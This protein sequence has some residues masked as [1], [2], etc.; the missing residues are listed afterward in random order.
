MRTAEQI[1]A[2]RFEKVVKAGMYADADTAGR[3]RRSTVDAAKAVVLYMEAGE[4]SEALRVAEGV[5]AT[6]SGEHQKI[7]KRVL[8]SMQKAARR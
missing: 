4:V 6:L 3:V 8:E 2:I 5:T 7:V 1:I